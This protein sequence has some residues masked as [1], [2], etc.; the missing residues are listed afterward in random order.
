MHL[1]KPYFLQSNII[2]Q[3]YKAHTIHAIIREHG[4]V[5][6]IFLPCNRKI[7][8]SNLKIA[9]AQWPWTSCSL[10]IV[11]W[12][13]QMETTAHIRSLGGENQLSWEFVIIIVIIQIYATGSTGCFPCCTFR[14]SFFNYIASSAL[15]VWMCMFL[16]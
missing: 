5:V 11:Q 9:T 2:K 4:G 8:G 16:Q 15:I 10:L 1:F 12:W 14:T 13:K 7:L 3:Y 6:V